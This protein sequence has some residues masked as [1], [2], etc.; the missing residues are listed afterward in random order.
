MGLFS[1]VEDCCCFFLQFVS[2]HFLWA[3]HLRCALFV[4]YYVHTALNVLVHTHTYICDIHARVCVCLFVPS[5]LA[6]SF[7]TCFIKKSKKRELII[8]KIMVEW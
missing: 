2:L 6:I 1:G 5:G 4:V 7:V 3:L 8:I